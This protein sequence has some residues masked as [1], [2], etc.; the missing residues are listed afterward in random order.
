[1]ID[2]RLPLP[3]ERAQPRDA[4]FG[5]WVCPRLL[6]FALSRVGLRDGDHR[7]LER[8]LA[9]IGAGAFVPVLV[10][11]HV[12]RAVGREGDPP[13]DAVIVPPALVA[14]R[15]EEIDVE[16]EPVGEPVAGV[17]QVQ[18][19]AG[20]G[21]VE[22]FPAPLRCPPRQLQKAVGEPAQVVVRGRQ[23]HARRR[24][25]QHHA[26]GR[27]LHVDQRP[28]LPHPLPL[29]DLRRDA[30]VALGQIAFAQDAK[31]NPPLLGRD[32]PELA[33]LSLEA[34][35]GHALGDVLIERERVMRERGGLLHV[36]VERFRRAPRVIL[37]AVEQR[38]QSFL[39]HDPTLGV[40]ARASG[41]PG[42]FEQIGMH[43]D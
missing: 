12:P 42:H 38:H 36:V 17:F 35:L 4:A 34:P 29:G 1:M 31:V 37:E 11:A 2:Q 14:R 39:A 25:Q 32:P 40:L 21:V 24:E 23:R 22:L 19:V 9:V 41:R 6:A 15:R 30:L 28:L 27:S 10:V 26:R 3:V 5:S 20:N 33:R 43:V 13:G 8:P 7:L 16:L 18:E